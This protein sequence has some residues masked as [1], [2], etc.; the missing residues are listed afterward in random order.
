MKKLQIFVMV[1]YILFQIILNPIPVY[2]SC[3]IDEV[4]DMYEGGSPLNQ[5]REDCDSQVED[6]DCTI[7]KIVSYSRRGKTL[8]QIRRLCNLDEG[9]HFREIPYQE[10][11]NRPSFMCFTPFGPCQMAVAGPT[12]MSCVCM[13]PTGPIGGIIR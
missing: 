5:I 10:P 3:N 8:S 1:I 9:R 12:G 7:S 11:N 2:S 4:V 13:T 6:S